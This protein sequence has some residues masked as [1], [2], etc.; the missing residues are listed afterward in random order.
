MGLL[1]PFG[2]AVDSVCETCHAFDWVKH[3]FWLPGRIEYVSMQEVPG[4]PGIF[5]YGQ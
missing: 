3:H 1:A 4:S 2:A 5:Q